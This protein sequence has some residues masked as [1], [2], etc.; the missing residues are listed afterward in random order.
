VET[1][2]AAGAAGARAAAVDAVATA[3]VDMPVAALR[4]G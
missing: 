2:L 3:S 4:M 1:G